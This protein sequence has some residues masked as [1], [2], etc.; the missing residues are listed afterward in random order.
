M[1]MVTTG[2]EGG[3]ANMDKFDFRSKAFIRGKEGYYIM[4]NV[5]LRQKDNNYKYLCTRSLNS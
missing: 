2:E 1:R 4:I 3:S 5:S